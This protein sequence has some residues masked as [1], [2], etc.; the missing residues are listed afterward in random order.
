MVPLFIMHNEAKYF[1][2]GLTRNFFIEW[3]DHQEHFG[4]HAREPVWFNVE[5]E[6]AT[7][8]FKLHV[9]KLI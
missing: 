6:R 8:E 4:M 3:I 2:F 5:Q 7:C 9:E 1:G